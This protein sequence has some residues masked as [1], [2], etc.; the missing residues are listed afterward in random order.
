MRLC[1]FARK[2]KHPSLAKS[3]RQRQIRRMRET[4][5]YQPLKTFLEDQGYEVKAEVTHCDIVAMRGDEPPLIVEMK[6]SLSLELLMQGVER[7]ALSDT[8]YVAFPAG[9]GKSWLKRAKVATKLCRRLGLGLIS[10]RF[11]DPARVLVHADPSPYQPRKSKPRLNALLKEFAARDGDPNTGGQT[12]QTIVTA[13]RQEALAVAEALAEGPNRPAVLAKSLNI[14]RAASILQ[15][16]YYGWF[17]RVERG[18]Y[19]LTDHGQAAI[20]N[21]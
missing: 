17:Y 19:A 9:K 5:L 1:G 12:R 14:P 4:E 2:G 10:V 7:L 21:R 15:N 18:V 16:N 13:Y 20:S 3:S 8:V 11:G 6:T